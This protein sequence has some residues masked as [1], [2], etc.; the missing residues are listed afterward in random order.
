MGCDSTPN[1]ANN[2]VRQRIVR[3]VED[4]EAAIDRQALALMLDVVSVGVATEIIVCLEQGHRVLSREEPRGREA[5][6]PGTDYGDT[7]QRRTFAIT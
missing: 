3:R 6:D 4:D 1:S 7:H 5:R 2:F